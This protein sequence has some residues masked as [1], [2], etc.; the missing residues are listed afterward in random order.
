MKNKRKV[1]RDLALFDEESRKKADEHTP[2]KI[3]FTP[4]DLI[5]IQPLTEN[6]KKFFELYDTTITDPYDNSER[7]INIFCDG[8]A[9]VGKTMIAFYKALEEVIE[10]KSKEKIIVVRSVVETRARGFL[11]GTEEE[12]EAPFE[13]PYVGI[14]DQLINFQWR[15]YERLKKVGIIEFESTSN[16]RGVTWNDSVVIVDE[17]QNMTLHELDTVITRVGKNSRIVFCGDF[18]QSDLLTSKSDVSGLPLF[19]SIL[20]SMKSF[21]IIDFGVNDIV[22]SG[23]VREYILAK[24][25][26]SKA[27]DAKAAQHREPNHSVN[28][29]EEM[30]LLELKDQQE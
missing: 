21:K 30:T 7:N 28:N 13:L 2:D 11:P 26:I 1:D 19:K 18:E 3:K 22:R 12:K 29:N 10:K 6:Q 17:C 8:V 16:L 4:K 23:L 14:C 27:R 5:K 25:A 24:L 9:G 15:N 20:R